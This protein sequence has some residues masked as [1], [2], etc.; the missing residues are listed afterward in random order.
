MLIYSLKF[1]SVNH[2]HHRALLLLSPSPSTVYTIRLWKNFNCVFS[3]YK[4]RNKKKKQNL[5]SD[6]SFIYNYIIEF[7]CYF[8]QLFLFVWTAVKKK[9]QTKLWMNKQKR[10]ALFFC[11]LM[12]NKWKIEFIWVDWTSISAGSCVGWNEMKRNLIKN[13]EQWVTIEVTNMWETI[14]HNQINDK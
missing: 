3:F 7:I 12:T 14:S 11:F 8:Y 6:T 4:H 5:S 1:I 2:H 9:V 13:S 10:K